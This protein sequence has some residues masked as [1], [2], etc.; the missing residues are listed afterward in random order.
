MKY[1][2]LNSLVA[3][4]VLG[5]MVL[6]GGAPPVAAQAPFTVQPL[7]PGVY[8]VKLAVPGFN[9]NNLLAVDGDHVVLVDTLPMLGA[10]LAA[11][12]RAT[13]HAVTLGRPV[14]T[15]INTSWHFDHVG[16]DALFRQP[17]PAGEGTQ[18]ILA[19][20]RVEQFLPGGR[21]MPDLP[22]GLFNPPPQTPGAEPTFA[23]H[24]EKRLVLE[25]ETIVL[26]TVENAHSGADLFIY[27]QKANVL[28]AGDIYFGGIYPITDRASGGT[29]N[30][31]LAALRQVLAWIDDDTVVVP[32]HGQVGNRETLI[33]SIEMLE[34]CRWQVRQ[35]IA[36]GATE[37]EIMND[38]SFAA[39]D[40][41]WFNPATPFISGPQFR[42]ILYRDLRGNGNP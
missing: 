5:G 17:A 8:V 41:Q 30:G 22:V 4:L 37:D 1:S 14:D 2:A 40:A 34:G 9:M 31:T 35:L 6:V 11:G 28:Y 32:S 24:G 13:I 33:D 29:I 12:F 19:H 3:G 23:I 36:K 38:A 25:N 39:L 21:P 42:R 18:D 27:L 20:W 10:P 7:G 16:L 15:L 26:K